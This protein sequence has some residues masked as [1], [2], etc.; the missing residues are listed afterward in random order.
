MSNK[1]VTHPNHA[2]DNHHW[3]AQP[4]T[5]RSGLWY[6][7]SGEY[8][9]Y[10]SVRSEFII[11]LLQKNVALRALYIHKGN[12]LLFLEIQSLVQPRWCGCMPPWD[13]HHCIPQ[14]NFSSFWQHY[15]TGTTNDYFT[16]FLHPNCSGAIKKQVCKGWGP[17]ASPAPSEQISLCRS[18]HQLH[19]PI[20]GLL[21][22]LYFWE[23]PAPRL[24]PVFNIPGSFLPW[25]FSLGN[26]MQDVKLSLCTLI[27][28]SQGTNPRWNVQSNIKYQCL[29]DY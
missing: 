28:D 10:N 9:I 2:G 25:I 5:Q 29:A 15:L 20:Q 16:Q 3:K 17:R 12:C 23:A 27:L 6:L 22:M 26:T 11:M 24:P 8:W 21:S 7:V 13:S 1:E 14:I 18:W 19:S 4:E